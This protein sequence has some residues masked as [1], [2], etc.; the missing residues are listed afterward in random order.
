MHYIVPTWPAPNSIKSFI[1][2]KQAGE[3]FALS[4]TQASKQLTTLLN[5]PAPPFWLKQTHSAQ[6]LELDE[7]MLL[8]KP[9]ADAVF[10]QCVH[11]IC[12]VLTADCLPIFLCNYSGT[13]IAAIHAG[14]RGLSKG[15]IENTVALFY[16]N[17]LSKGQEQLLAYL[18]PAIGPQYFEVG[19]DVYEAFIKENKE[20]DQAFKSLSAE[21]WLCNIY[22]LAILKL[23]ALGVKQIFGGDYCTYS[24]R[25]LFYSYRRDKGQTGRMASVIWI[26]K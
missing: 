2:T 6:V 4:D 16:K 8:F 10:T 19:K 17:G 5:L 3:W 15:I 11:K 22:L 9:E 14:W 12:M 7:K 23:T 13:K 1:T 21:K 24:N 18:G 20:L 26:N 25:H